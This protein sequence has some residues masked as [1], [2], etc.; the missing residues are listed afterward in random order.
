MMELFELI[1]HPSTA[2]FCIGLLAGSQVTEAPIF[3]KRWPEL[4]W[5][6]KVG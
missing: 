3:V 6:G 1:S 4:F 2:A 5:G